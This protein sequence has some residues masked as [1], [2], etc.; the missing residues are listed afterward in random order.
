MH[1]N[2][3]QNAKRLWAGWKDAAN[4]RSDDGL[5][6]LWRASVC[7]A[8]LPGL[9]AIAINQWTRRGRTRASGLRVVC[10]ED[11]VDGVSGM[12]GHLQ[13][14]SLGAVECLCKWPLKHARSRTARQRK[15]DGQKV[16][17]DDIRAKTEHKQKATEIRIYKCCRREG[18]K[19]G[20][21]MQSPWIS[22]YL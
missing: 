10:E 1:P 16:G 20:N 4:L 11:D 19:A 3:T 18:W 2:L 7:A 9:P 6:K 14:F 5:L 12:T 22:R 13:L 21:I 8:R 17:H 15:W